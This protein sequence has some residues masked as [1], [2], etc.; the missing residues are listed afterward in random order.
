MT[1]P[2]RK[3]SGGDRRR[4]GVVL[5]LVIVAGFVVAYQFVGPPPPRTLV[6]ATGPDGGGYQAFGE[7]YARACEPLGIELELEPTSGSIENFEALRAGR[8]DVALVQGG[9]A[10]AD[11][12]DFGTGVASVFHEPLW[13][14][15]RA[16]LDVRR[17]SD[18]AGRRLEVG[19]ERS[20]TRAVA[21]AL[22]SANGVDAARSTWLDGSSSAAADELLAG[23]VDAALFVMAADSEIVGG[24]MEREGDDLTLFDV[25][26][27]TAYVRTFPF[28]A[29]VVLAEG[30]LDLERNVPSRSVD[31]V[32]PTAA[33]CARADLHQA[34]IPLLIEVAEEVHGGGDRW[35]GPG[36]FPSPDHLDVPL[37][38]AA[39]QYFEHG[40]SFL[41]RVFPFSVAAT[42]DRL[43][44]MLLPLLTLLLPLARMAP[45]L[46]RW[47][48]RRRIYRWYGDLDRIE[49]RAL[50]PTGD[51]EACYAE[52]D[53]I[54]REIATTVDVPSSYGRE[55]HDLRLHLD[56]LRDRM[57][58]VR[59]R[60]VCDTV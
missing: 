18:L 31:L 57:G 53:G 30:V 3:S 43:K 17:L 34:M 25:D 36:H 24:L 22:L 2:P 10:P 46:L 13:V 35:G 60:I 5:A 38:P 19:A 56:R 39:Q 29:H 4:V 59:H 48:T 44:I 15:H 16:D 7:R 49:S 9:T 23:T 26:R 55:L 58:G 12:A 45:P 47:R 37:A 50:S 33:L 28:L 51:V 11:A 32:A 20:G 1:S 41:Y 40:P 14:F 52:L 27:H 21:E 8:V 54:E 42:L 6:L